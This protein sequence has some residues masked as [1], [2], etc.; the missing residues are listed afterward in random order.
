MMMLAPLPSVATLQSRFS[1]PAEMTKE[2]VFRRA[3]FRQ[4]HA[5]TIVQTRAGTLV[6]A[7]F[8]GTKEGDPD[9]DIYVSRLTT[10]AQRT[11][12][13]PSATRS[14]K[15][16]RAQG[17]SV[18]EGGDASWSAPMEVAD[19]NV[20]GESREPC[21]NPVL[22]Q[23]ANGPLLL[24]Y[25]IG[26]PQS[27]RGYL[28]TS[29]DDGQTWS[30][31]RRLPDG[32]LGP[33]KD[34]PLALPDGTLLCGASEETPTG[35]QIHFERTGAQGLNWSKTVGLSDPS[36]Q[37]IQPTILPLGRD[38][39]RAI[40]RTAKGR[41]FAIDSTDEGL[42][43]GPLHLLDVPNPNSGID[44]TRLRDGRYLLVY[45]P[46]TKGRSPLS[47]AISSDAEHWTRAL[48]LETEPGEYSYPAVIQT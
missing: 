27:W 11:K 26:K 7:W 21:Y 13:M 33:V 10:E 39:L 46:T 17:R 6:T 34:K 47:V 37:A 40:G 29:A 8:G 44:A 1:S 12:P 41:V 3:P 4:C 19:G 35:R 45:N 23:P 2:Y 38:R 20:G 24:F 43:W 22:F 16:R 30:T 15:G 31:P 36:V 25:H 14:A 9:V 28:K 18:V 48:D 42:T 5:S 32:I